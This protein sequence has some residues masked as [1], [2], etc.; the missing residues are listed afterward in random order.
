MP[1]ST[2]LLG[3]KKNSSTTRPFKDFYATWVES[4]RST[5]LPDL[6]HS[7]PASSSSTSTS[8]SSSVA[9]LHSH[10]SSYFSALDLAASHDP[11]QLLSPTHLRTSLELPF[12]FLGD[13][14]PSLFT[15]LLRSLLQE[16][17]RFPKPSRDL[18]SKLDQIERGL[19]LIVPSLVARLGDAQTGFAEAAAVEWASSRGKQMKEADADGAIRARVEALAAVFL[20]ANRLRRSVLD[21]IIAALGVYQAALYLEKLAKFVLKISDPAMAMEFEHCQTPPR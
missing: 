20:D 7:I 1:K 4:L 16:T 15:I 11:S 13:F 8:L 6:R 18:L 17:R 2:G 12:L 10:F 19:R 14:H 3:R 5:H 9:S 21:E